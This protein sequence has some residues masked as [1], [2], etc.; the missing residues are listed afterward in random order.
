MEVLLPRALPCPTG[1]CPPAR[2]ACLPKP[3]STSLPMTS[4]PSCP[5]IKASN[6]LKL[7]PIL[8]HTKFSG[9][10]KCPPPH[11]SLNLN[12]TQPYPAAHPQLATWSPQTACG[13]PTSVTT[14]KMADDLIQSSMAGAQPVPANFDANDADNLEDVSPPPPPS[15]A[16]WGRH[17]DMPM[18]CLTDPLPPD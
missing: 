17:A 18:A 5:A 11:L 13:I 4:C 1:P 8:L 2:P 9:K 14:N 6:A 15:V 12:P 16:T 10:S 3:Y 7:L